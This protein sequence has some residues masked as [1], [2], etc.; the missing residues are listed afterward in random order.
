MLLNDKVCL[1][2][3]ASSLR[4]IGYATAEL[5]AQHGAT[6]VVADFAMDE[7]IVGEI[8]SSIAKATGSHPLIAGLKCDIQDY[9]ECERVVR[10]VV[11]RFGTID[12]LVNCAGVVKAQAMLSIA[13]T[14]YDR[15]LGVNLKGT[16]NICKSTLN[17]FC[18]RK[19]GVI[20]NLRLGR[21]TAWRWAG[22]RGALRCVQRR[23]YQ[24]HPDHCSGIWPFRK[25]AP[26]SSAPRWSRLQ[27]L[28]TISP[29]RNL[30]RSFQASLCN[31]RENP[32]TLQAC[33]CS[34]RLIF[35][36][37]SPERRST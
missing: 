19:R 34:W 37:T 28:T 4:G 17:T 12:C 29:A 5:F 9:V 36:P 23:S 33:V 18:A 1:I 27:C 7:S 26:T 31:E 22:R 24:S 15:V 30:M 35:H 13:E 21:R 2:V 14:D 10:E 20:V 25:S 6:L 32:L 16:F 11:T 8:T 3:G